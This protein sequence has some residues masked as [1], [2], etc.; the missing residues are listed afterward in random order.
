MIIYK[1]LEDSQKIYKCKLKNLCLNLYKKKYK[2]SF[3]KN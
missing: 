1:N 3:L 2:Y